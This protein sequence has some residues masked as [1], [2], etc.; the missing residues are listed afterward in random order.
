M[1]TFIDRK[2]YTL[3]DDLQATFG[4]LSTVLTDIP[5]VNVD[6]DG[7]LTLRGDSHV[8]ILVDGKPSALFSGSNAGENLQSFPAANIERIEVITTPPP[9]YRAAGAAGVINIITRKAHK[10]GTA[11]SVR[12]SKGSGGLSVAS[13][14]SSY[15]SEKLSVSVDA[16]FRRD[17]RLKTLESEIR[18]PL[19]PVTSTLDTRTSL[20]E[21]RWRDV[22][23]ASANAQYAVD[24]KDSLSSSLSWVR[25]GGPRNYTQTTTTT[26]PSGTVTGLSQR[27]SLGHAPQT[28]YDE[29]LGY[30]RQLARHGEE[31][32]FSLHRATSHQLTRYDYTDDTF[33]PAA[34]P[35]DTYLILNEHDVTTEAELDYILPLSGARELKF[36]YLLE[37]DDYSFATTAGGR[38]STT[39]GETLDPIATDDFRYQQRIQA[40]YG[41]YK[42]S[43][44]K[45]SFLGGGR[46]EYTSTDARVPTKATVSRSRYLDL[47]PS[48]HVER[49][50]SQTSTVSFG[51]SR[52][53]TRPDPQ[54][55]DP[56][57]D[58][59]YTL[60][61]RAGNLNLLP[62]YTQSYEL[63]YGV[64]GHRLSYQVTAYYRRNHDSTT[65]IVE[66]V[67]N[68]VSLSTQENFPRDDFAGLE[69]AADGQLGSQLSYSLSGDLF[70]GQVDASALGIPGVRSTHGVDAKLKLNYRLTVRDLAQ[71]SFSRTDHR[72]SAQGFV[73]AMDV[74]NVGYRHQLRPNL[75]ALATVSDVFN[76]QRTRT[77]VA[78]PGFTGD[79]VRAIRGPI[80]Y[81]GLNYSFG[82]RASKEPDFRYEH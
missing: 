48:L 46:L 75:A 70:Q 74:V 10:Q 14:D 41:S 27:L 66:Y 35:N 7:V 63:G 79:F 65:G 78:G 20:I 47:F 51:A 38:D 61:L 23:S 25:T 72:L 3:T 37:Q 44:G 73:S 71:L 29:R 34:A 15:R 58:P 2:V 55:L 82:S 45:W 50:L 64:Q 24:E 54:Q 19:T 21:H 11:G 1:Q 59:E 22:P 39:G 13:A 69:L 6:P 62:E 77:F 43:A 32:D 42:A 12:V 40:L 33:L 57:I 60:I 8:L 68:G 9:Q 17:E 36:G 67:G 31:L 18:S 81:V 26:D 80:I 16:G 30:V 28:N 5:S 56:N 53:V 52:R 4:T 76:G 49:S